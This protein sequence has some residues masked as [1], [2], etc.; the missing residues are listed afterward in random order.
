MNCQLTSARPVDQ[1]YYFRIRAQISLP[2]S[3]CCLHFSA[4]TS[5]SNILGHIFLVMRHPKS[6]PLLASSHQRRGQTFSFACKAIVLLQRLSASIEIISLHNYFGRPADA[7]NISNETMVSLHSAQSD[8]VQ[9]IA[10]KVAIDHCRS[11]CAP[12]QRVN[13]TVFLLSILIHSLD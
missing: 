11:W 4:K 5:R 8:T 9:A 1:I 13:I 6:S 2:I 7:P 10:G 3:G 12:Y